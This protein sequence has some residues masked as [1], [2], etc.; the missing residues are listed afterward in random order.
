MARTY[1]PGHDALDARI[2]FGGGGPDQ[3]P[4]TVIG[5]VGDVRQMGLDA[6]PR[7]E[8]YFPITQSAPGGS[9][10]W[11]KTLVVRTVG[12]PYRFVADIRQAIAAVDPDQPVASIRT[13]NDVLDNEVS[14]RKIQMTILATFAVSALLLAAVGL[15]GVLSYAVAQRTAEIGIRMALGAERGDMLRAIVAQALRWTLIGAACGLAGAFVLARIFSALLF[16]VTPSDPRTYAVALI[17]LL[18]VAV[19]ASLVPARRAGTVDPVIALGH[20]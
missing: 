2:R 20:E 4:Y 6:P 15:Y 9:F 11:P 1:W 16:D 19:L 5:I 8:M 14:A 13:M 3:P 7:P 18:V 12:D 10:F 17:L